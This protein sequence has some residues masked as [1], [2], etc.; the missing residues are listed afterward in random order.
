MREIAFK[1]FPFVLLRTP[2][3][4]VRLAYQLSGHNYSP[5][6]MEGLYLSSP[7][8]W[9]EVRKTG[10][11]NGGKIAETLSKYWLRSCT[12]AT[13]YGTL[14]GCSL[15]A[16]GRA[17]TSLVLKE[18]EEHKRHVRL[19]MNFVT[20]M[21]EAITSQSLLTEEVKLYTNN[22]LY[23]LQDKIRYVEYRILNNKRTYQLSSVNGNPYLHAVLK[24]AS[25][26]A[27]IKELIPEV[28]ELEDVEEDEARVFILSLIE[29]KILSS[30]L[31][32]CVT[33][34]EPF[35]QLIDKLDIVPE[36]E[37]LKR[38]MRDISHSLANPRSGID[39]FI[40]V[41]QKLRELLMYER[42]EPFAFP[43][44]LFQVDL[45]PEMMQNQMEDLLVEEIV[46]QV[47]RLM[48]ISR[49][50]SN[51]EL[52][53]FRERF[54]SK[55]G[56]AQVPLAMALDADIGI[57]YAGINSGVSGFD[58][59][60]DNLPENEL[61][62]SAFYEVD[63][64][65]RYVIDK[66]HHFLSTGARQIEITEDDLNRIIPKKSTPNYPNSMYIMGS[67][68]RANEKLNKDN[69]LFSLSSVDGPSGARLM[70]RFAHGC[71]KINQAVQEIIRQE[72]SQQPEVIFAEIVHLPQAR[73]G[74]I[75]LRPVFR[76]Y[77]IPYVGKSGI[78]LE[79][80]LPIDDLVIRLVK[81]SVILFSKKH[82]KQVIPRLTVAHNF[83]SGGLPI[84]K[85]LCDLQ[86]QGFSSPVLWDW[87]L[88]ATLPHLPRVVYKNIVVRKATWKIEET[89]LTG[90]PQES[91]ERLSYLKNYCAKRGIPS[92]VV[93]KERDNDL[94]ID[95]EEER[96]VSLFLHYLKRNRRLV[97]EEFLVNEEN[98]VVTDN[99][100][101][102]FTNEIII[103]IFSGQ[104]NHADQALSRLDFNAGLVKRNFTPHSEWLYFKIYCGGKTAENLL[105]TVI[106]P[107]IEHGLSQQLF[108]SF[109]FIRYRE[110][111]ESP[112]LRLRFF[113]SDLKKQQVVQEL[114]F[115]LLNP[116][117][118]AGV[119]EKVCLDTYS[120]ELERYKG[121]L[122]EEAEELFFHDSLAVIRFISLLEDDSEQYRMLF[123][124]RGID[125]LLNDFEFDLAGKLALSGHIQKS[126]FL[127]FGGHLSLQKK[128]NERYRKYQRFIFSHMNQEMDQHHEIAE[129]VVI[130]NHRSSM[131]ASTIRKI[132]SKLPERRESALFSLLPSYIHMFMNR[133]FIGKQRKY[134]L[135]IYH[136]LERYYH[137]QSVIIKGNQNAV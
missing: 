45:F 85:F 55:Y 46:D 88:L 106:N 33:G 127:E 74:N 128:L 19:D 9:T 76:K 10:F 4:S 22:T 124:M 14:A 136:F 132:F 126:F 70:G 52:E 79:E 89:E 114:F 93:Y 1:P 61:Q 57:G 17:E 67:L 13:P 11:N 12:R 100:K 78:A 8:F 99:Q 122:I 98:F 31:E 44:Q 121:V 97:I 5:L 32:P 125:M 3:Q 49:K 54:K 65:V 77:E 82:N 30:E 92:R 47:S 63:Y 104:G 18:S 120:R 119:I 59:L 15:L 38:Q 86:F 118:E 73:V 129:G 137:S 20:A 112:H 105:K 117:V 94:L 6:F 24:R 53:S 7:D 113:N 26:G 16:V 69:F 87:G 72:E 34:C 42:S 84:Y 28:R 2:L 123:A 115:K 64:I 68:F 116:H 58:E 102:P 39:F 108:E 130:F 48:L 135:V 36:S 41:E 21:T 134:E 66:Y 80:Q 81:D 109:F 29:E 101:Q 37:E 71:E 95:F 131:N 96:G 111:D 23:Y 40:E 60:I 43:K 35:N 27:T 90:T 91:S 83:L 103:P 110:K 56:D 51:P 62:D 133:L 50:R 107:F 25:N 75:L